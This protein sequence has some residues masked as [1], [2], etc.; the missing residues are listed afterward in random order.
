MRAVLNGALRQ[1]SF[2]LGL[3]ALS[4]QMVAFVLIG[5]GA[6]VGFVVLSSAAV[7]LGTGL[8]D[9]IV[10]ALCYAAFVLPVYLLHRRFTFVSDARHSSA[11]PRYVA[12][13]ISGVTLASLFSFLAYT[14]L[15]F[16]ALFASIA[17]TALTSGVNFAILK[18][19]AFSDP[20]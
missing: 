11:L 10:S 14:V 5:A 18:L 19:W 15:G 2:P 7:G 16:P 8:P 3:A 12:V 13:Q 6:A 1:N 20:L 17:V 9:W 4:S